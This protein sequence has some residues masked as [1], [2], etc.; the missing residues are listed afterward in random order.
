[1]LERE[2]LA[3]PGLQAHAAGDAGDAALPREPL[4][5]AA[6]ALFRAAV[7]R[8][9]GA[10][11][12]HAGPGA[13]PLRRGRRRRASSPLRLAVPPPDPPTLRDAAAR[14]A[15]RTRRSS[16]SR[17]EPCA[18]RSSISRAAVPS[19]CTARSALAALHLLL[20][21]GARVV[22]PPPFLCCGFP[23]RANARTRAARAQRAARHD[24]VLPDPRDV[25][26]LSFDAVVVT[27]GTC[28]E[29]LAAME[30]GKIFG[31]GRRRRRRC[32]RE[33]R[34][35]RRAWRV[36]LPRALSRLARGQR[37]T[38]CSGVAG[39][40][41]DPVPH[42]CSEAGTLALSRPDI[43]EAMLHRKREAM[44]EALRA[45]RRARAP[46]QLPLMLDG[47]GAQ[48]VLGVE[49]RH[50]VVELAR[51]LSGDGWSVG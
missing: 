25:R 44:A 6:T 20:E 12:R 21:G 32:A 42:C 39:V 3:A 18:P 36:P 43:A 40:R 47:A 17:T 37:P 4:A 14:P 9:G 30:A 33:L 16:S 11:Q 26:H 24:R 49:A 48:A 23:A 8:A 51:T 13:W 19:G 41:L 29:A 7:L 5:A 2:I 27:C 34:P 35:P 1:M 46:D 28:R 38:R 15:S 10:V 31:S 45:A 50:V 22:L